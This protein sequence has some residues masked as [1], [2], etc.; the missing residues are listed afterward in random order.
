ME[1]PGI[2]TATKP[3]ETLADAA[4]YDRIIYDSE[5]KFNYFLPELS[6]E[7]H[8]SHKEFAKVLKEIGKVTSPIVPINNRILVATYFTDSALSVNTPEKENK[9]ISPV[10]HSIIVAISEDTETKLKVGD[11]IVLDPNAS[12]TRLYTSDILDRRNVQSITNK[13]K[14]RDYENLMHG[15]N[16]IPFRILLLVST[17]D[18]IAVRNDT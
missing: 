9:S 18:V 1:T 13:M 2:T 5:G 16:R 4:F 3:L 12:T 10:A 17:F 11:V 6:K 7:A 8:I 15:I 14:N